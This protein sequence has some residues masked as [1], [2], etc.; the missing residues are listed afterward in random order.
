MKNKLTQWGSHI[1]VSILISH[2]MITKNPQNVHRMY[3]YQNWCQYVWTS[4]CQFVFSEPSRLTFDNFLT[5]FWHFTTSV[6]HGAILTLTILFL[7]TDWYFKK[8]FQLEFYC[9]IKK[10]LV[11]SNLYLNSHLVFQKKIVPY[12]EEILKQIFEIPARIESNCRKKSWYSRQQ[13]RN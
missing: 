2:M 11:M 3:F 6:H 5:I 10:L 1:F 9:L 8:W 7:F 13:E 12:E 4:L